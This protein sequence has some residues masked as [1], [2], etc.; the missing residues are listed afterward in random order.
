MDISEHGC[1]AL[2]VQM[3]FPSNANCIRLRLTSKNSR[4]SDSPINWS[5]ITL[6]DLPSSITDALLAALPRTEDYVVYP[7]VEHTEAA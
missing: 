7:A 3:I 6:Y 1:T 2:A 4:A 5:E